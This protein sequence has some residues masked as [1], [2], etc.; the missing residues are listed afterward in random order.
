M[1]YSEIQYLE[2]EFKEYKEN[3][4]KIINAHYGLLNTLFLY[5]DFETKGLLKYN[6]ILNK[7]LLDF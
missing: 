5:V 7:E 1:N 6:H 2:N 4:D 3:T